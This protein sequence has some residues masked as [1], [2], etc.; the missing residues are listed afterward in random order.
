M[1]KVKTGAINYSAEELTKESGVITAEGDDAKVMFD[2]LS[3]EDV[4]DKQFK[5]K[6]AVEIKEKKHPGINGTVWSRPMNDSK[7]NMTRG[8]FY[9]KGIK[10]ETFKKFMLNIEKSTMENKQIKEFKVIERFEDGLPKIMYSRAKLPMM[11]DRD[12]LVELG[13]NDMPDGSFLFTNKSIKRDD[14]PL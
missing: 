5:W 9:L 12:N 14:Y 8:E 11:T 13:R 6:K 2:Q 1:L 7:V 3:K 4:N 10:M